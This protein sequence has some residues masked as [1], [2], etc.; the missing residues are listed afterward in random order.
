M[1]EKFRDILLS[2][3]EEEKNLQLIFSPW[4]YAGAALAHKHH[5]QKLKVTHTRMHARTQ[6]NLGLID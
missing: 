5:K 4:T 3:E 2:R 1:C 6:A